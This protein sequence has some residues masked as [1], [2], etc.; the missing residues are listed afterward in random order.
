MSFGEKLTKLRKE[1]CMSQEDLANSLNVSRQAVSKWESNSS[2]PE[3]EKIV[4]ICK[5]FNYSMDEIIGLK[6]GKVKQENKTLHTINEYFDKFIK[7]IK[8]FYAMTFK[9]KIKCLIEM[10]FYALVLFI[11]FMFIRVILIEIIRK[12]LSILPYE[13]L[14]VIIQIFDGLFY[15]IFLVFSIYALVKLYKVRYLDYYEDYL[16]EKDNSLQEIIK[17]EIKEDKKKIKIK[18]EKIIIRDPNNTFKPFAWIK[19]SIT[20]FLKFVALLCSIVLG[21]T[22]V[23]LSAAIIFTLYF[24]KSGI[25]IF[26]T[27]L[28][29]CG[30]LIGIYIFIEIFIKFIFNMKQSPKRLFITFIVSMLTIGL[31][32]GLFACEIITFKFMDTNTY[33][34]KV[35][36]EQIK[37]EDNLIIDFI[38]YSDAEIIYE[39]REDIKVE[40]YANNDIT[41]VY[42]RNYNSTKKSVENNIVINKKYKIYEYY[43]NDIYNGNSIYDIIKYML[44]YI[45]D[46]IIITD[47]AFYAIPKVYISKENYDKILKNY[48]EYFYRTEYNEYQYNY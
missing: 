47:A 45:E 10:C 7:G 31:S 20:L 25:I 13:L 29:L 36:E 44:D 30:A 28:C 23:L 12:L 26:Y 39:D 38:I 32:S 4:A 37:M 17:D 6:E 21:I 8:M 19:K 27:A 22:F 11:M 3:T 40:F 34:E 43:T 48:E 33:S 18:E 1:R 42:F 14:S 41:S 9:Q 35:L 15:L 16:K 2:Y 46:K 5:L 24:V